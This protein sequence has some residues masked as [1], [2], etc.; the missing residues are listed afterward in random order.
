LKQTEFEQ[1]I[2]AFNH[3]AYYLAHDLLEQIWHDSESSDRNFYQ[4]LLQLAVGL[5]H[6]QNHNWKGTAILLGEG[7]GKLRRYYPEYENVD[8]EKLLPE[9]IALLSAVQN[10]GREKFPDFVNQLQNMP[11]IEYL[12]E[13]QIE[14]E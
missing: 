14:S 5:Y 12:T 13:S 3:Q 11:K 7:I 8:L 2:A 4:G 6:L 10:V 1:A 9:A